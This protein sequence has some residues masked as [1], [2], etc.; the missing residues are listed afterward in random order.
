VSLLKVVQR[1]VSLSSLWLLLLLLLF[2]S[3]SCPVAGSFQSPSLLR[4]P[5]CHHHHHDTA[6]V[7]GI[8]AWGTT[9]TR[10]TC[11][12]TPR[13]TPSPIVR[14]HNDKSNKNG[15][16]EPEYRNVLTE[17]L[18]KFMTPEK[19]NSMDSAT[20]AAAKTTSMS[21]SSS[22]SSLQ[23]SISMI[24]WQVSKIP[25]STSFETLA[26]AL[27][28]ELIQSEWFVTGKVNPRYVY[29]LRMYV[30][31]V[32]CGRREEKKANQQAS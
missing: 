3:L 26:Q 29:V 22:S 19:K 32:V 2:L 18:S 8:A 14:L 16:P 21:S 31:V 1:V 12:F 15:E 4:V 23:Q 17:I 20:A 6:V 11:T 13:R 5:R 30:C 24:D 10:R 7:S 27:E 25:P 28:C 9:T